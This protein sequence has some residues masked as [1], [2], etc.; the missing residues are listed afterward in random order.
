MKAIPIAACGRPF[1]RAFVA[2]LQCYA[3]VR[4]AAIFARTVGARFP[5]RQAVLGA[6]EPNERT[7]AIDR[8]L[9]EER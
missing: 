4:T 7:I 9:S 1:S 5:D 6:A 3:G 2:E 8:A